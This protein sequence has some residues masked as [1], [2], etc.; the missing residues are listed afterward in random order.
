MQMMTT[1]D[2]HNEEGRL[3]A[4]LYG[5]CHHGRPVGVSNYDVPFCGACEREMAEEAAAD[6]FLRELDASLAEGNGYP[7][8]IGPI[9]RDVAEDA[10][11]LFTDAE[12]RPEP[13]P[14]LPF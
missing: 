6:A 10:T 5:T 1:Q 2:R 14:D 4:E 8:A 12:R 9:R 11:V 3:V 7:F 13:D